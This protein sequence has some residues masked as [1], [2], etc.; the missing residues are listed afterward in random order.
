M[1]DKPLQ[2]TVDTD[3]VYPEIERSE[4]ALYSFLLMT[5]YLKIGGVEAY[6]GDVPLCSLLIP[7]KEIKSVFKK[8]I[9]DHL[10]NKLSSSLMRRIQVALKLNNPDLLQESLRQYLLESTSSFDVGKEDFYHGMMLGLLSVMSDEYAIRFNREGGE[11]RFDILL[12][13]RVKGLPGILME[14]KAGKDVNEDG[15]SKLAESAIKQ[16]RERN[17]A[18]EMDWLMLPEIDLYGIAFSKKKAKVVTKRLLNER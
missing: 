3:I 13:P 8:E 1:Q 6:I 16:I 5:G 14:F 4:D 15:L 7:N 18:S 12:Q 9:V 11:G 10:S 17:Y 2:A